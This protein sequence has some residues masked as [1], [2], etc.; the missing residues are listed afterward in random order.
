MPSPPKKGEKKSDYI[1]RAIS[2]YIREGYDQD[3]AA[4]IAYDKWRNRKKKKRK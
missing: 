3:Q 4:A 1:S 2:A